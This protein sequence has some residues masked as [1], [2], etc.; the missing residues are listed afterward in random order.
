MNHYL[1]KNK[2]IEGGG[3][4]GGG[5]PPP[6]AELQPPKLG[7]MTA[8]ASYSY[9]ETIDL[10]SDGPIEGVVNQ[11][12]QYVQGHRIFE[13]IY[14]D[15]TPVKKSI[16]ISYTG[17]NAIEK[18]SYDL[19][20]IGATVSGLFFVNG[21]FADKTFLEAAEINGTGDFYAYTT[22]YGNLALVR[23]SYFANHQAVN[24]PYLCLSYSPI[25]HTGDSG[26]LFECADP[27]LRENSFELTWE[28]ENT[29]KSIYKSIDLIREVADSPSVY[30]QEASQTAKAKKLRFNHQSWSEVRDNLLPF[31]DD[32][33]S[34][35]YPIFALKINFGEPYSE[36]FAGNC[37]TT[38][39]SFQS[40]EK[41]LTTVSGFDVDEFSNSVLE[42]DI[43]NQVFEKIELSNISNFRKTRPL[44]YIDLTY[45]K[46]T[47]PTSLE[48]AGSVFVF[49]YK[50]GDGPSKESIEAI[51]LFIKRFSIINV[52]NEKYNY[53]NVLAEIRTGDDLQ[54]PL[55]Y[56]DKVFLSKEYGTKL[57]GPFDVSKQ[58]LRI[59]N[60]ADD[61]GFNIRGTNEFPLVGAPNDEG[62]SDNR[63]GKDFSSFAG[64]SKTTFIEEALPI[65][66]V[67][68]NPNVDRVWLT[69]G[70]RG[71]YDTQQIDSALTGIGSLNAG[72]KIPSVV[73][74]K[75]EIGLQDSFGKDVS[76][77]IEERIYQIIG[78]AESPVI[79]DIGRS[80]NSE[81]IS[82]FKFLAAT[83]NSTSI[84]AS[85]PLIVPTATGSQKRFVRIT[86][87]TYETSSTLI[88]RE[89]SLEKVTEVISSS[90]S[91]PGSAIV[92]T[93][94]DSRNI[95]EIPPRSFD[96][97]LKRVL[98][99]SNYFPL[100]PDGKD[101]RRYRT[102]D[103]FA[104]ASQDDLQIYKGNWD[105]TFKESWTDNPA[106]V[107]FDLLIDTEYGLGSFIE[108]SNI[109]IWEL[110]KIGRFCDSV[111]KNGVFV[112]TPN[113]FGGKEPRHS[114]NIVFADKIDVY[115][116][117]NA[118]ASAF[119]GGIYYSNSEINFSDDR[120]KLPIYEFSNTNV[121]N[122]LFSYS[123][124]RRDQEFNVAEVSYL[125]ESDN[126]KPK[127]EYVENN[128]SIRKRGILKTTIDS[129][130][131]TSRSA[132]NR[133]GQHVLSSTS[134]ENE[135]VAFSAGNEALF[136]RPGDLFLV[137]DELKTSQRN[138]GKVLDIKPQDRQVYINEQF[139]ASGLMEISLVAPTG[140][141]SFEDFSYRASLDGISYKDI[142]T[143]DVPQIQT[144][145]IASYSNTGY[146]CW[147]T[148]DTPKAYDII[149]C[150]GISQVGTAGI[151]TGDYSGAGTFGGYTFYS[152]VGQTSGYGVSRSGTHWYLRANSSSGIV[153]SGSSGLSSPTGT[154]ATGGFYL[155]PVY[156]NRNLD[157]LELVPKGS[158]Y[159]VSLSGLEKQVYKTTSIREVNVGEYEIAGIKFN[160]GKFAKIESQ[161]N[162]EDFYSTFDFIQRETSSSSSSLTS[163][164]LQTPQII[165]FRTGNYGQGGDL[166]ISGSW[167]GVPLAESY[168]VSLVK[169]NGSKVNST[170]TGTSVVFYDQNQLGFYRLM[171]SAKAS[172]LGY[173]SSI[174]SSGINVFS[175]TTVNTPYISNISI[176]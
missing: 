55:S 133:I 154:W 64:S 84:D 13:G 112:G 114:I 60:F 101:K 158:P 150:T 162:L 104:A 89:I 18:C 141:T 121:K 146:G 27:Y 75:V 63:S 6:P 128:D 40:S 155:D 83:K 144:F 61:S 130:G 1:L 67:V 10:V 29:A 31:Y 107:L 91:Y 43:F 77:S 57:A 38:I 97:R 174:S 92:A 176:S 95:S 166:D 8:L 163:F 172:S 39:A 73:R 111:D 69:L 171:V 116:T 82:K 109:N 143:S 36:N 140:K 74:F 147:V 72:S 167:S 125:D 53:N 157:F 93:K 33:T 35:Q 96:L 164:Q 71:L 65:T 87:T 170:I 98:V 4:K 14:F 120:L 108:P 161:Q 50:D 168:Q 90:F 70:V 85:T 159:V 34:D 148:V 80:E 7:K 142:S 165:N 123:S 42:D 145:K 134:D 86:R 100:R 46:K 22:G 124:S 119:K 78:Y 118:I 56:F 26:G 66:H 59:S 41:S 137:N 44:S 54:S 19:T 169:P 175:A 51:K 45:F 153:T 88:R 129:F 117:I 48:L 79:I 81:I 16:D 21:Q 160:S 12:G 105:G 28:R 9:A 11:N 25:S 94:V 156:T 152:G 113:Q 47:T 149:T 173:S 30:G 106:W 136:L 138:F 76:G 115:Q 24:D 52:L 126:F 110:Y 135:S 102:S 32:R 3:K 20:G 99:P 15:N 37:S 103:D 2:G 132:A 23:R 139:P 58:V 62:S 127:V 17:D 122:G 5:A 68:E 131:V 151:R 49:G